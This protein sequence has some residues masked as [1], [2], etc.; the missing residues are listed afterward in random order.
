MSLC[1]C[2]SPSLPDF[3]FFGKNKNTQNYTKN[4]KSKRQPPKK[5]RKLNKERKGLESTDANTD[6]EEEKADRNE[7]IKND[8]SVEFNSA[9][10]CAHSEV[11]KAAL[12]GGMLESKKKEIEILP[13]K[14]NTIRTLLHYICTGDI[15]HDNVKFFF[16]FCVCVCVFVC[17]HSHLTLHSLPPKKNNNGNSAI[18]TN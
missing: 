2:L 13:C 16:F 4:Q 9:L 6:T 5:E 14:L 15:K 3:F 11:F 10:L 17:A 8:K 12:T 1:C 7:S 18:G